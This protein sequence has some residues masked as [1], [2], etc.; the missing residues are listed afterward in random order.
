MGVKLSV[1]IIDMSKINY[2]N[3]KNTLILILISLVALEGYFLFK[4]KPIVENEKEK[5]EEVVTKDEP[6]SVP[7]CT[8]GHCPTFYS[9]SITKGKTQGYTVVRQ[10]THMTK[11]AGEIWVIEGEGN[12]VIFRSDIHVQVG[13]EESP[14]QDGFY[15]TYMTGENYDVLGVDKVEFVD[16]L[17]FEVTENVDYEPKNEYYRNYKSS[18]AQE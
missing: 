18:R 8:S 14:E 13:V 9:M 17:F 5:V 3:V 4:P 6:Y 7:Y 2:N 1:T 16:G 11:G 10:P 12:R 15:I